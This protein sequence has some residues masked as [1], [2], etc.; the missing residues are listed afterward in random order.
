[1]DTLES[2]INEIQKQM[3]GDEHSISF[4]PIIIEI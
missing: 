2:R 1:M 4:E 3:T